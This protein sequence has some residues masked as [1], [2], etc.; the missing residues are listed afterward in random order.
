MTKPAKRHPVLVCVYK[1][2]PRRFFGKFKSPTGKWLKI[3]GGPFSAAV[4]TREKAMLCALGWYAREFV[5]GE[6]PSKLI[7]FADACDAFAEEVRSRLRGS[8]ATRDEATMKAAALRSDNVL[9]SRPL[10]NHDH[11]L[12]L[13]W[14]REFASEEITRGKGIVKR[15]DP[16]TIRNYAKVLREVYRFAQRHGAMP[17]SCTAPANGEEFEHELRA[18]L[19]TKMR[20]EFFIEPAAIAAVLDSTKVTQFRKVWLAVL[21]YTGLRPGEAHGLRIGDLRSEARPRYLSVEQQL[22]LSRKNVPVRLGTLKTKSS[23]RLIPVHRDLGARLDAWIASGWRAWVGREPSPADPLLPNQKGVPF[24][25]DRADEFRALLASVGVGT[26]YKGLRLTPY[27]VRHTFS[28]TA[29]RVGIPEEDRDYLM[30]HSARS[31]RAR[32]YDTSDVRHLYAQI[33]KLPTFTAAGLE[34]FEQRMNA[35]DGIDEDELA[36]TG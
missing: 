15:R 24:R 23:Y 19:A 2:D 17:P 34:E 35:L 28:S 27:A 14:L 30:G 22:K 13:R 16:L 21:I 20:R 5:E 6:R 7:T 10:A 11:A 12:C 29:K 8:D 26:T 31:T 18:L 4:D 25:E 1:G 32:N 33:R 9:S 3:P 36:P